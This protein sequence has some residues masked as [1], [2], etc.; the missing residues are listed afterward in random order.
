MRYRKPEGTDYPHTLNSTA[1]ATT[2]ALA[3]IIEN[4]QQDDGSIV[5]PP[6]LQKWM[7][8]QKTIKAQ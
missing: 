7:G 3:A 4:N 6:I 8:N 5:I 2:R 1:I